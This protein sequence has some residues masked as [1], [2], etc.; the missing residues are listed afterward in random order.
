MEVVKPL[1]VETPKTRDRNSTP[2]VEEHKGDTGCEIEQNYTQDDEEVKTPA[3][4]NFIYYD[5]DVIQHMNITYRVPVDELFAKLQAGDKEVH[6][7]YNKCVMN[8][9]KIMKTVY[10]SVIH[11]AISSPKN[12][13]GGMSS[14]G[15]LY[16][17]PDDSSS[18]PR[19][20]NKDSNATS[21]A[22]ENL[23]LIATSN[24]QPYFKNKFTDQILSPKYNNRQQGKR[25]FYEFGVFEW[26]K[27]IF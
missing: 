12:S 21:N 14:G 19:S 3:E 18:N 1:C 27:V 2:R 25:G 5:A 23:K 4:N 11:S 13:I 22:L 9:K 15:N 20:S 24:K 10:P 26:F 6:E 17:S 7:I 8:K 16:I